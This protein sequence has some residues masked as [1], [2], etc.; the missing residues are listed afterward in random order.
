MCRI[1][2]VHTGRMVRI[3]AGT[4]PVLYESVATAAVIFETKYAKILPHILRQGLTHLTD[5]ME[6]VVFRLRLMNNR[7]AAAHSSAWPF[8][9]G[10]GIRGRAQN[11]AEFLANPRAQ[12]PAQ[13]L[14]GDLYHQWT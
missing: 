3:F 2:T 12:P 6:C 7:L 13:R 4:R 9:D 1:P 14:A 5:I 11:C 8:P 10:A